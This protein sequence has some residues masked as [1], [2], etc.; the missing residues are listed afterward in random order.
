MSKLLVT[1]TN[2]QE[3]KTLVFNV[4]DTDIAQRWA[5]EVRCNYDLYET[6]RFQGW[7]D[8]HKDLEYYKNELLKQVDII[9][10][11]IPGTIHGVEDVESQDI[12]NYLHKFFEDLL[13][14]SDEG[15]EFYRSAPEQVRA[16]IN[17]FNVLI[18]ECEHY[19][20][21]PNSPTIVVTF[22]NSPRLK[23][24]DDDHKLF[25]FKW[26]YGEVYVNYCEVGK[27]LLDVFKDKD[28][29]VGE[30]NI[31]PQ[32][33]FSADFMIKFGVSIPDI[34]YNHRLSLFN[35]WYTQQA[36]NFKHR[37]LGMI[38]VASLESGA[39]YPNYTTVKSV[40]IK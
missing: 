2:G 23:L 31:R 15:T 13:G 25:T 16:A 7:P 5:N 12:L 26:K 38:P 39:A 18:H 21:S 29:H 40:C 37:S 22:E 33:Y 3:D 28:D 35:E 20:R 11:Y 19:M 27:P 8:S 17:L 10:E 36:Y 6:N 1:L 32:T 24:T 4:H 34:F 9:N 14:D 30:E